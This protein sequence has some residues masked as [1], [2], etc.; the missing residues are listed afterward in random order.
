[1]GFCDS[2]MGVFMCTK[3]LPK[4]SSLCFRVLHGILSV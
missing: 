1:M 3:K 2:P 4:L